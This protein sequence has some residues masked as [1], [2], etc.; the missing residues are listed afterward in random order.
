MHEEREVW[1]SKAAG[2]WKPISCWILVACADRWEYMWP[3]K[4]KPQPYYSQYFFADSRP[5]CMKCLVFLIGALSFSWSLWVMLFPPISSRS[6]LQA[7]GFAHAG[8]SDS[9]D[10][11][12]VNPWALALFDWLTGPAFSMTETVWW[13]T[14]WGKYRGLR[15][16][17]WNSTEMAM[18]CK[19]IPLQALHNFCSSPGSCPTT[20]TGGWD[21]GE[22]VL[23]SCLPHH[24][25]VSG[26]MKRASRSIGAFVSKC[27]ALQNYCKPV[28][29]VECHVIET[30]C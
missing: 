14:G 13:K 12:F 27:L 16:C 15:M 19:A 4:N 30:V 22:T 28:V 26:F 18:A 29:V 9:Y 20:T 11:S 3:E 17:T 23:F 8:I 25:I 10:S 6:H 1:A 24:S 2:T 7:V 5:S 21:G